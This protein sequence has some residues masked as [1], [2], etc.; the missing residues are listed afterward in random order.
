V[1]LGTGPWPIPKKILQA[2][3]SSGSLSNSSKFPSLTFK[4]L[5]VS[6]RIIR[7]N[8]QKFYVVPTLRL[9][10]LYGSRNEQ[11]MLPYKTLRDWFYNQSGACL[12]RGTH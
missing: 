8:I 6:L 12:Q 10:V 11:Q 5:A 7:F 9:C 1:C 2:V 3:R 4:T